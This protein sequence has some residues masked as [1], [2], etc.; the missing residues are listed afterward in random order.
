MHIKLPIVLKKSKGNDHLSPRGNSIDCGLR[1]MKRMSLVRIPPP[2]LLCDKLK[3]KYIIQVFH[4]FEASR[5]VEKVVGLQD[6]SNFGG[7]T[8]RSNHENPKPNRKRQEKK[9]GLEKKKMLIQGNFPKKNKNP[10]NDR[11]KKRGCLQG[12]PHYLVSHIALKR[13]NT[14]M[15]FSELNS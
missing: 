7:T 14:P 12:P 2:L 10:F 1:L 5:H 4:H 13:T 15:I 11:T 6:L 9:R 8:S 3:K